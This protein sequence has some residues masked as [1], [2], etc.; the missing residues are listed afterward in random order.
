M[1]GKLSSS[2]VRHKLYTG[3][4]VFLSESVCLSRNAMNQEMGSQIQNRK[5][6]DS[7][8]RSSKPQKLGKKHRGNKNCECVHGFCLLY[9]L[10]LN[11]CVDTSVIIIADKNY[12]P[13]FG[14]QYVLLNVKLNAIYIN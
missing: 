2:A 3:N 12:S 13:Y 4:F 11:N 14:Q 8:W 7:I 1:N 5:L 9:T 6:R 10:N